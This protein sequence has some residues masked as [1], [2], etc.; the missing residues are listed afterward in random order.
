MSGTSGINA[1]TFLTANS[2]IPVDTNTNVTFQ[3]GN[4]QWAVPGQIIVVG[5]AVDGVGTF[6]IVSIGDTTHITA[7][8]LNAIGD[9]PPTSPLTTGNLAQV[10]P[11]GVPQTDKFRFVSTAPTAN[12]AV[13]TEVTLLSASVPGNTLLNNGDS[14]EFEAV[15]DLAG[16]GNNTVKV[17]FG[18]TVIITFGPSAQ[19]AN[20]Y[21]VRGRI[22]RTGATAQRVYA[23]G[24]ITSA[25]LA[26]ALETAD[27]TAAETLS[28]AVLLKCTGQNA[29][30][31]AAG[32]TQ[33]V[34][35]AR[36]IPI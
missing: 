13:N 25:T 16:T 33:N 14:L 22:I 19:N 18:G 7:L 4:S 34:L 36:L 1:F 28:G 2:A 8:W 26:I 17:Y 5:D 9:A 21:I 23:T 15:F 32:V 35:Y 6:K 11:A 24:L 10:S 12:G 30:S 20:S 29:N 3:V 27:G 31:S